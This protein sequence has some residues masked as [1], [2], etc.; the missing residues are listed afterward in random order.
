MTHDELR[1]EMQG[2][3][4]STDAHVT[5]ED[6]LV[7]LGQLLER[8]EREGLGPKSSSFGSEGSDR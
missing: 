3:A 7:A 2:F 8:I 5:A 1:D 6:V 4:D